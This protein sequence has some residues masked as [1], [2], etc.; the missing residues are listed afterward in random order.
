MPLK[1][2]RDDPPALNLTP[3]IDVMCFLVIFF[4][5]GSQY[6]AIGEPLRDLRVQLPQVGHAGPATA[7]TARRVISI[8]RDGALAL[9]GTPI[10]LDQLRAALTASPSASRAVVIR[11]D[12]A[13]SFQ[14]IANV[15]AV[16]R[17]AGLTDLGVSVRVAGSE[18]SDAVR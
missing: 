14:H 7:E 12:A 17:Q 6:G 13:A 3:M 2:L 5:L 9:D 8:D 1:T 11:G 10:Q 16:C 15:L 18:R 4:L